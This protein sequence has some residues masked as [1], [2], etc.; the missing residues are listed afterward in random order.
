MTE[1]LLHG[2]YTPIVLSTAL[3]MYLW[4]VLLVLP[5]LR[6]AVLDPGKY[7]IGFSAFQLMLADHIENVWYG[8]GRVFD[9]PW[10]LTSAQPLALAA[11][12]LILSGTS[13]MLVALLADRQRV[14]P[15]VVSAILLLW[16]AGIVLAVLV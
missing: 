8:I 3:A 15:K 11:K 2:I 4:V 16:A 1:T 12:T 6:G 10:M 14:V 5:V 13:T 7:L 9:V